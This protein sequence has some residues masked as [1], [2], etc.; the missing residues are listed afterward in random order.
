MGLR[1]PAKKPTVIELMEGNPGKR[2]PNPREPRPAEV[3]PDMPEHLSMA[4]RGHWSRMAGLLRGMRVLTEADGDALGVLAQQMADRDQLQRAI[5]KTGW[6][7]KNPTTGAVHAN[8]LVA[9]EQRITQQIMVGLREFGMT[10]SA[11]SRVQTVGEKFDEL[12]AALCG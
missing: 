4:A 3:E 5:R 7:I 9:T 8:P 12:E 1:G 11:R 10:P 6:L 2:K